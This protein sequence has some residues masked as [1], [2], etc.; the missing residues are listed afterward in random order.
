MSR[1]IDFHEKAG[2]TRMLRR[3]PVSAK[4][5]L[6]TLLVVNLTGCSHNMS[7]LQHW[8]AQQISK[9]GG[10][11]PPI[12]SVPA[13]KAFTYPGHNKD[14]FDSKI[15]L[16]LY[17]AEHHTKVKINRNRPRQYLEQFPLDSLQM[18]GT[19]ESHG[20]TW[21]LIETPNGTIQRV[22]VGNYMGQHDGKITAITSNSVK[23]M[24]IVPDS[25]GGYKKQPA[26][27]AMSQTK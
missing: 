27:I 17:T 21:A 2:P 3:L 24:E 8:V 14:P 7:D 26:A 9:P 18:V 1:H 6:A 10:P 22:K 20:I 15:L 4:L 5:I 11:V 25:F 19:L 12:P 23:L 13:Y 16:E